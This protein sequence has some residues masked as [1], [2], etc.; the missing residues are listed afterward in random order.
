MDR[1]LLLH[2]AIFL[3][4]SSVP[5]SLALARS[6]CLLSESLG[7][8]DVDREE[9]WHWFIALRPAPEVRGPSLFMVLFSCERILINS[10]SSFASFISRPSTCRQTRRWTLRRLR[11]E[12][13]PFSLHQTSFPRSTVSIALLRRILPPSSEFLRRRAEGRLVHQEKEE[14]GAVMLTLTRG[15]EWLG[16]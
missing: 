7:A 4:V 9:S 3:S 13:S 10:E 11:P 5:C 1:N 8:L 15:P 2:S 16:F 6:L 14:L 12:A